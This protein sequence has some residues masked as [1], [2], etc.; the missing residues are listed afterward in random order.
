MKK[1]YYGG[2]VLTMDP[3]NPRVEALLTENGSIKA[4][5]GLAALACPDAEYMDLQ[6]RTLMPGFVDGHSH[7]ASFGLHLLRNC[8]LFGCTD[9]ADLLERIRRFRDERNLTHGE[10][11]TA[12]GYDPAIMAENQHPTAALLDS[13]G[14]DN[15]IR[16]THVSGHVA[17]YNTRAMKLAGVLEPGY[18]VPTGGSAGRDGDGSL[19]GYFEE[20]AMH[21][22]KAVFDRAPT[23]EEVERAVL[24]AQ[25]HYIRSGF[26]T[27][28]EGS[29]N[30]AQRL[31][32]LIRLA[33]AG[34]LK[35][36]VVAY[37]ACAPAAT[38]MW[39]DVLA[40][41]GRGY[42]GNLKL[43]GIKM[44]LDGSPQARTAWMRQPYEDSTDYCGYPTLTMEQTVE[45]IKRA[46]RYGLQPLAHCNGDAACEQF[47]TAWEAAGQNAPLRPV[48]IHAQFV[49]DDQLDRMKKCGM[50]ASFFV[51]HC[52]YWGDTHLQNMGK[53]ALR[54]SPTAPALQRGIPFSLHQDSPVTP[55]DMLHSIWCAVNRVTRNGKQLDKSCAISVYDA[56]IAATRGG[57]YGYFEEDT[58]GILQPG[59]TADFVILDKDP[60]AVAPM[61]I[62]D[63]QVL[64]TIKNDIPLYTA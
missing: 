2:T 17:A 25:E 31:E 55:P 6:G 11:I 20:S 1:L 50:M 41:H 15:P 7:L 42:K 27:V 51:G 29:G 64:Q 60:T 44:F 35:P 8:D 5:G 62:R 48:M 49:G 22:F 3:A 9:L 58:K 30:N 37:M 18:T 4:L 34:K 57:A 52:W 39:E 54:I 53:R 33:D 14:F 10:P 16:C 24:L 19:T 61:T 21:P 26:T 47:L 59:A 43:G 45:R 23:D 28:Q 36:D 46:V 40:R 63:I 38:T 12:R 13:L 32:C 56:L